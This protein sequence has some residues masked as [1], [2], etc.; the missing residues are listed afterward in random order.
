MNL[1]YYDTDHFIENRY[2]RKVGE[3]FA[4]EGE[5]RFRE[6]ERRVLLE[7]SEF[8]DVVIAT[9]GG[10]PCFNGN[11]DV[12]NRAGTTVYLKIPARELASRLESAKSA[13]PLLQNRSGDGLLD[14]VNEALEQRRPFYEKAK[15]IFDAARMYTEADV[16]R[17]AAKLQDAISALASATPV[18]EYT[19]PVREYAAPVREYATPVREYATSV[20]GDAPPV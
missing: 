18:R 10:M 1:T 5:D 4:L 7:L 9:G 16:E 2:R 11:I 12:M 17:L 19:A 6:L 15:I 14:F 3:I 13:R 20:P 8:E